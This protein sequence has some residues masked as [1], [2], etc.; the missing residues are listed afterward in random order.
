MA[1]PTLKPF[2]G[3]LDAPQA[4][5]S[6]LKPFDGKLD[7]DES[8]RSLA[9]SAG[10]S[11]IALGTG[12][13]Q[14][15][16]MLTDVAGADNPVSSS[17][18]GDANKALTDLESPYRK[19]QKQERADKIK[20]AEESGSTWEEI[21]AHAGAFTDAPIDTTLNALGTSA[22]TIA[23][24]AMTGGSSAA[25]QGAARAAPVVIGAAQGAGN[26][27]GQIHETVKQKHMAAGMPEA[28][29]TKRADAAQAYGG[30]NVGSIALGGALGGL[31]G[32]SGAETAARNLMGRKLASEAAESAALGVVRSAVGGV[33]KEAPMEAAQGGQE[34]LA[35][36]TALQGE[37]FDV[38]T[39]QGV[40]GQA[41]LEGLASAP[42]GGGFGAV[43][44]MRG[45][46]QPG[47][48]VAPAP[49]PIQEATAPQARPVLA[50]PAPVIDV[51]AD[52][53]A[54]T[55]ADRNARLSRID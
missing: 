16:K 43:E 24:A 46:A 39:W 15:V 34:R 2:T 50:L 10:D 23:A 30:E 28:E 29:A 13:V 21:K 11:A 17:A 20:A 3:S 42:V 53:T 49:E 26:V 54:S 9:R 55:A 1:D 7:G 22:P 37:G 47:A 6:A 27:K 35:S 33:L 36:N 32:G 4:K 45:R 5:T 12:V 51:S 31:A 18:L 41:A 40:A 8:I 52:G 38:P 25:A 14:G 44:G 48:D 19:A